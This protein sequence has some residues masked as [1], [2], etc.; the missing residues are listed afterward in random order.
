MRPIDP[1]LIRR[2]GS[3]RVAIIATVLTGLV[4]AAASVIQ[5]GAAAAVITR[6]FLHHAAI[7]TLQGYLVAFGIA[8]FV[9]AAA[10]SAQDVIARTGGLR[11]VAE[12]RSDVARAFGNSETAP[13]TTLTLLSRGI[14]AIEIYVS[15]YLP[16]LVL[17]VLVPLGLGAYILKSDWWS[18]VV[19]V[20]T[21]P[22]IPLFMALIGWFTEDAVTRQ[23]AVVGRITD[24]IEDLFT[25]LPDL[26]IFDRAKAQAKLIQDLGT[27]AASATMKV[28]R[29]S[30]LS[31][32]ALELLATISVAIIALGIGLRLTNGEID[33]ETGLAVLILAPDVYLPIRLVGTQFH[34]AV[35]GIGA[36]NQAQPILEQQS[37]RSNTLTMPIDAVALDG[38][39][40]GYERELHAPIT[41]TLLPGTLT[42]ITGR[43]G[44]GKSTLLRAIAGL[45]QPLRGEVSVHGS[46]VRT[47]S[48]SEWFAQV[49]YVPQDPWL[50]HG[51]IRAALTRGVSA[52]DDA[53]L[54]ALASVG[55]QELSLDTLIDDLGSGVS[56]GQR[57]RIALARYRLRSCSILLL[58]EPTAAVDAASEAAIL[59]LLESWRAEGAIIVAVAHRAAL[60][61][62]A[63]KVIHLDGNK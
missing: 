30:F 4:A 36:W 61:Q 57:R 40:V 15:R 5:A 58:D 20:I 9:R 21:I 43:S 33:L 63:Q 3:I 8:W 44:V 35:E 1:A 23:W 60:V 37:M 49:G 25:G 2:S 62:A 41:E 14:D 24:V 27:Q 34:A 38:V 16:Q 46:D 28:L 18:A 54:R 17:A 50:G 11:A 51:S 29:I 26:V 31:S 56:I 59:Q 10:N 53:C 32:L 55:L 19:L 47:I 22:L 12:L 39:V 48:E 7:S 45:L 42:A 52:S 13:E 6:V